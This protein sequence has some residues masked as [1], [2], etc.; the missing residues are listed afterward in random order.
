MSEIS[1]LDQNL[2][3]RKIDSETINIQITNNTM[4]MSVV[5]QFD[6]NLKELEKLTNTVIFFRGNS[7]TCKG[8]EQN[9]K[10]FL[11]AI[12]YLLN[13]YFLT[14]VIEKSDFISSVQID[15]EPVI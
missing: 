5:G 9:I 7:I 4:L 13:K 1:K 12:K 14:S 11:N 8:K 2:I 15:M 3:I 10:E 6:Q